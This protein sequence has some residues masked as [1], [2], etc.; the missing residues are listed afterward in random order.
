M[1]LPEPIPT[2]AGLILLAVE[3]PSELDGIDR[4]LR[5]GHALVH[6]CSGEEALRLAGERTPD[7]ILLDLQ[8]PPLDGHAV[9][10]RLKAA[11][12][13]AGLPVI[14]VSERDA[15]ED[16]LRGLELGAIDYLA[17][18]LDPEI[19]LARVRNH[20]ALKRIQDRLES[21]NRRLESLAAT[22]PLTGLVNRRG[23][24]ARLESEYARSLRT[25]HTFALAL[26]D[27]DHFK[28]INDTYGHPAGDRVLISF[29]AVLRE[30]IRG[31]DLAARWGGEE[32]AILFPESTAEE[33]ML[34]LERIRQAVS[35]LQIRHGDD[36]IAVTVSIG[37]TDYGIGHDLIEQILERADAALYTAKS[38]GRNR[39]VCS[40]Q[41]HRDPCDLACFKLVWHA[42]YASEHPLIDAQHQGLFQDANELLLAILEARPMERVLAI[43]EHLLGDVVTHFR[44]EEAI[45]D[46]LGYPE[47]EAHRAIHA[48]LA[49]EGVKLLAALRRGEGKAGEWFQF[50]AHEVVVKHMLQVDQDYF[51]LVAVQGRQR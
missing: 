7:L 19:L 28:R 12:P 11:P 25:R 23:L 26:C 37:V 34:P 10:A 43:A 4:I 44:D 9:C 2:D 35:E 13:T 17:K 41:T 29:A 46:A 22:D 47:L 33:A 5:A 14:L 3:S 32:F 36:T 50:L 45:L 31:I 24:L 20:L 21:H 27:L 1:T 16:E 40:P 49:G 42:R 15:R 39:I 51:P 18:P 8:T 30:S 48:A 6:A 38:G